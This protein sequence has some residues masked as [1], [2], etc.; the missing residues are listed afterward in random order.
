MIYYRWRRAR[1]WQL[2]SPLIWIKTAS[3]EAR[4]KVWG[5]PPAVRA[6]WPPSTPSPPGSG[7]LRRDACCSTESRGA[8]W[9]P[10]ISAWLRASFAQSRFDGAAFG[11]RATWGQ[12][13]ARRASLPPA[14]PVAEHLVVSDHF[15]VVATAVQRHFERESQK[16]HGADSAPGGIIASSLGGR[17]ANDRVYLSKFAECRGAPGC[18]R[19]LSRC[20]AILTPSPSCNSTA[21]RR[22]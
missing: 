4:P 2:V 20:A 17:Q 9:R 13:C 11:S 14:R 1:R 10:H 19:W 21:R 7:L 6:A 12:A 5:Y 18:R 22:C 3:P 15:A 16:P 8:S